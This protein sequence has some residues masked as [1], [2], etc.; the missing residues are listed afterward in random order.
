MAWTYLTDP[1]ADNLNA[2]RM[3]C[4]QTSSGDDVLIYDEEINWLV[5]Q[6]A[7][8]YYAAAAACEAL[9][10]QYAQRQPTAEQVGQLSVTWG[11]RAKML[12]D[13]AKTLRRQAALSG[14]TPFLGGADAADRDARAADTGRVQPSFRVGQFDNPG[15]ST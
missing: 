15:V 11:D 6:K 3:L 8:V 10:V 9:A 4:G 14:A 7:S 12:E 13:R 2:V 1:G 5:A